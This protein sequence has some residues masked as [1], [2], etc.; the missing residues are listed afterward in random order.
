MH[1]A[2]ILLTLFSTLLAVDDTWLRQKLGKNGWRFVSF[3]MYISSDQI[4]LE[5]FLIHH[6]LLKQFY[7]VITFLICIIQK[8]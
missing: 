5:L 7:D 3:V 6:C 1:D 2:H 4:F 8:H